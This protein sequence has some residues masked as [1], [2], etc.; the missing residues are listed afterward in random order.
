MIKWKEYS[1]YIFCLI[2]FIGSIIGCYWSIKYQYEN[3]DTT[4][5]LV[6]CGFIGYIFALFLSLSLSGKYKLANIIS[7][8][9]YLPFQLLGIIL[10][11]YQQLMYFLFALVFPAGLCVFIFR[12]VNLTEGL[13]W[14]N[15]L[16][17][18]IS[19]TL[20]AILA[21]NYRFGNFIIKITLAKRFFRERAKCSSEYDVGAIRYL[22]YLIYFVFL[23]I[24]YF[25]NFYK[26]IDA[27]PN[28]IAASFLVYIAYDRL[29]ANKNLVKNVN[30][31]VRKNLIDQINS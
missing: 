16:I 13:N 26:N 2:V 5:I 30:Q 27:M 21:S 12:V 25:Q 22:I 15:E 8:I 23:T 6:F 29:M 11:W 7:A 19:Y 1:I 17:Y 14:S 31:R 20:S 28:E 24:G 3:G 18:F 9:M 10:P 4:E